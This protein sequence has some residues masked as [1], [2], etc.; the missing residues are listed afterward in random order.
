MRTSSIVAIP[1]A[2]AKSHRPAGK[3]PISRQF[4][5]LP[6][7]RHSAH[8]EHR[9]STLT[10]LAPSRQSSVLQRHFLRLLHL[11]LLPALQTVSAHRQL[12]SGCIVI[13]GPGDVSCRGSP[14]ELPLSPL[15]AEVNPRRHP[16]LAQFEIRS[17]YE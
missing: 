6:L 10:A 17:D 8:P 5:L 4:R 1:T 7:N 14:S 13:N 3:P 16:V 2:Q 12:L 11:P 9:R 15:T